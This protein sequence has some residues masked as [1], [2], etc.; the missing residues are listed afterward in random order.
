VKAEPASGDHWARHAEQWA[1]VGQPLRPGAEDIDVF[2]SLIAQSA[3]ELALAAPRALVL[4]VTPELV[5]M[6]WPDPSRLIAIDRCPGM[7]GALLPPS[8][9]GPVAGVCGNW[10]RLP[11]ADNS[12]DLIVGDGCLTV[13]ESAAD[14]RRLGIELARILKPGGRLA[15]RLFVRPDTAESPEQVLTDLGAGRIGNF[16]VFKWRLAMALVDPESGAVPVA[17]IWQ[18]WHDSGIAPAEL[19]TERGWSQ[20][21]IAT[22]EAYRGASARYTFPRLDEVRAALAAGFEELACRISH[23][24]LG[25]RCPTLLLAARP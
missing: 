14:H 10:M 1:H 20:A 2:A 23:Y 24:E 19:A 25:E 16:H 22:I 5:G 3:S 21:E 6:D 12:L 9:A 18:A 7:I 4:G 15:L 17:D 13:L 11:F 8:G